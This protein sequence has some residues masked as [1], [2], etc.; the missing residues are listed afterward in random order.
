MKPH[1][2][3]LTAQIKPSTREAIMDQLALAADEIVRL[4]ERSEQ[5]RLAYWREC[6][7]PTLWQRVR[8]WW[9]A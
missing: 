1:K 6:F 2:R 3:P 7:K 5:W 9:R 4:S 8:A